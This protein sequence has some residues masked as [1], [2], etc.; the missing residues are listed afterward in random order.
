ML[1]PQKAHVVPVVLQGI[2]PC[3]EGD[4]IGRRADEGEVLE[5]DKL[6]LDG[7]KVDGRDEKLAWLRRGDGGGQRERSSLFVEDVEVGIEVESRRQNISVIE[8]GPRPPWIELKLASQLSRHERRKHLGNLK[9]EY[10]F[11]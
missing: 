9:S 5:G 11:Q 6:I 7:E 3:C 1:W 4:S 10:L 2:V 8:A